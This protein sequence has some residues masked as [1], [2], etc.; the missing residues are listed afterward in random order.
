MLQPNNH[1]VMQERW[2]RFKNGDQKAFQQLFEEYCDTLYHFGKNICAD[3]DL[4]K[5]C[6]QDLFVEIWAA[7]E[8]LADVQYPKQ[9]L[10]I[11]LRR[12]IFKK[13]RGQQVIS[14]DET[15]SLNFTAEGMSAEDSIIS[16]EDEQQLESAMKEEVNNLPERQKEAIYLRYYQ[17][18][19]YEEITEI[20]QLNYQ[21]VRNLV[22]RA[23]QNLR[24]GKLTNKLIII[25]FI[26]L[27]AYRSSIF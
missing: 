17:E 9:Y 7:R 11:S 26:L 13:L 24:K 16:A 19:S 5:D 18:L 6:I 15:N 27:T 10:M 20:M 23:L 4:V 8:R 1:S 21:V 3:R 2:L 14:L 22:Y 12:L 25:A